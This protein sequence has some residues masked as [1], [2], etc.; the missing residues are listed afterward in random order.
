MFG[1][2]MI[3]LII[4]AIS[5]TWLGLAVLGEEGWEEFH[6]FR[7]A[8]SYQ[9]AVVVVATLFTCA[10]GFILIHGMMVRALRQ[11]NC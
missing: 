5:T 2:A 6:S 7:D 1:L 9:P 4:T 11:S 10:A 3:T 8:M